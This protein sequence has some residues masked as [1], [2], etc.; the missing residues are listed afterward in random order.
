[1]ETSAWKNVT[2]LFATCLLFM[3][4]PAGGEAALQGRSSQDLKDLSDKVHGIIMGV[5]VVLIFPLGAMS[6]KLLNRVFSPRSLLW[7]HVGCQVVGLALLITGFG[8]GVWVA[9]LHSEACLYFRCLMWINMSDIWLE[10][11]FLLFPFVV[12][13]GPR[14]VL[15]RKETLLTFLSL[16]L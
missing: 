6:W 10:L 13:I 3:L 7:I 1:M 9:I 8:L 5:T 11:F 16:G 2:S 15:T 14:A 4:C 12:D